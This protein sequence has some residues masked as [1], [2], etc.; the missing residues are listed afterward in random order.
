MK[1]TLQAIKYVLKNFLYILPFAVIPAF[2]LSLSTDKNA[3]NLV[4]ERFFAGDLK[5]WT[6][7]ELF[8]AISILNFSSLRAGLSGFFAVVFIVVCC[9]LLMAFLEKHMRIGKRSYSGVFSKLNDNLVS[10]LGYVLLLLLIYELWALVTCAL[11]FFL[12]RLSFIV[13]CIAI[14]VVTLLMF[15]VLLYVIGEIYLWLPCM[16]IT[17]FRAMEALRYSN[18]LNA[19]A[20]WQIVAG[21]TLLIMASEVCIALCAW[22]SNGF[23]WFTLLST[24]LYSL[25]ILIYCV[26]MQIAY[27][28]LDN[29]DRAD[30]VGYYRR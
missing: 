10:T 3:I 11:L 7:V 16:Q 27:F 28:H 21:Q 24:A 25:L 4:I 12:S 19:P 20:Q 15:V 18:N 17:G 8:R 6:F 26:R 2:F 29:I 23:L 30:L 14:G 1:Y 5:A 13:A 9:A 22:Y